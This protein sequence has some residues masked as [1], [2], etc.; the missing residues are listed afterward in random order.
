MASAIEPEELQHPPRDPLPH[1]I[2]STEDVED[3]DRYAYWRESI[4]CIFEVD[5]AR[6]V[7]EAGFN[8]EV[9]AHMLGPVMLARTRSRRQHWART[10]RLM[11]RDGMDHYMVQLFESGGMFWEDTHGSFRIPDNGLVVFDLSRDV[12]SYTDD[13]TNLSLIIPRDMLSDGLE[14]PDD[15]HLRVLHGGEPMVALLRDHMLSLKRL[16]ARM[17]ARQAVTVAPATAGLAAACLNSTAGDNPEQRA[18][19]AMAQLGRIRRFVEVHLSDPDLSADW[20][21]V[22]AGVS[23]SKLYALFDSFG[24]VAAYV[25]ERR[26]RRALL[27]LTDPAQARR[28]IYDIALDCGYGSD[29][30]FSRAFRARYGV[31]PADARQSGAVPPQPGEDGTGLDRRYERWLHHLSV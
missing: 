7:R 5:A 2:F 28:P 12:G 10:P 29:T 27:I 16:A 20:I 26:L 15:Q 1:A 9:D 22:R 19:I 3:G 17:S 11:A 25:R 24:G 30:A 6:D 23:R 21:A 31:S 13:F 14:Q 18:G 4:S 8:A